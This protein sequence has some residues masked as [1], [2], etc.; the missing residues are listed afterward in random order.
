[1]NTCSI[2][3]SE[4]ECNE[5]KLECQ[6]T[7]HLKCIEKWFYDGKPRWDDYDCYRKKSC[8]ICRKKQEVCFYN[9][10]DSDFQTPKVSASLVMKLLLQRTIS[11]LR[12]E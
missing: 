11:Y 6:H 12:K 9:D 10:S 5:K 4:I 1:M 7:F 3:F 8:P 2:C